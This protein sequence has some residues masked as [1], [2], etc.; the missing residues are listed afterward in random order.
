MYSALLVLP[1]L[2]VWDE[3][4]QGQ[5]LEGAVWLWQRNKECGGQK[6]TKILHPSSGHCTHKHTQNPYVNRSNVQHYSWSHDWHEAATASKCVRVCSYVFVCVLYPL[7]YHKPPETLFVVCTP[8]GKHCQLHNHNSLHHT[9]KDSVLNKVCVS[10]CDRVWIELSPPS[11]CVCVWHLSQMG[12]G[13]LSNPSGYTTTQNLTLTGTDRTS[14]HRYITV[15]ASQ[16]VP[17]VFFLSVISTIE[18]HSKVCMSSVCHCD[19]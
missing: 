19:H 15:V 5:S 10:P 16:N 12:P 7:S 17:F 13:G 4:I 18:D 1:L 9:L 6:Y 2:S 8:Q 14:I 3:A 11:V